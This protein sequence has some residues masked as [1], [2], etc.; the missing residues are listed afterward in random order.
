MS[1]DPSA[2]ESGGSPKRR[3]NRKD[4]A[5]CPRCG[6]DCT[7]YAEVHELTVPIEYAGFKA[8][9]WLL[10]L[11]LGEPALCGISMLAGRFPYLI[12]PT[13]T[14]SSGATISLIVG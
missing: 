5:P 1:R 14:A 4:A 11:S 10:C 7:R 9:H 3:I 6:G 12:T 13:T 8:T 2:H